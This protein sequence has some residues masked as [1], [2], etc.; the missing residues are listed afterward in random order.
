MQHE[1]RKLSDLPVK[2]FEK[3]AEMGDRI[4]TIL[5]ETNLEMAMALLAAIAGGIIAHVS[6]DDEQIEVNVKVIAGALE[7]NAKGYKRE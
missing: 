3:L 2:Q 5:K 1:P 6:K 4:Q 7:E